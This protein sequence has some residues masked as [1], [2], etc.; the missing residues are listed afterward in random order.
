MTPAGLTAL[1][2]AALQ[3]AFDRVEPGA[4]PVVRRSA[5][6]GVDFQ[7]NGAMPLAKRLGQRPSELAAAVAAAADL[8]AMCDAVE[9]AP[10]GFINLTLS[11]SWLASL[12]SAQAGDPRLGVA[13]A[14][15]PRTVVVDY[16][17]PNVAK[18]MHAGHLRTTVIGDVICR[19]LSFAGHSVIRENHIGDWG[20]PFGMLIEHLVDKGEE[21]AAHELSVGDLDTFYRQARAE[22][23][24]SEEFQE[25]SRARVVL[26]QSGDAETMRL[27]RLLV[28][29]SVAYFQEVY[30]KLGVLL[31]PADIVGESFYNDLLP[32]VVEELAEQGLLVESQGARCVFP[33]GWTGRDGEPLPLIVQ[34]SDGG[35]GYA[36]TDLAAL[37]DRFGRLGADLALYVVGA[38]QAQHLAMCFAVAVAAGW[39]PS[40]DQAVHVPFGNMLGSDRKMF[41][42]RAGGTVKL[43]DL[44]D[45]AVA[46]A[47]NVVAEKNPDL[48]HRDDVA[49]MVGIGALKYADLSTDRVRDYVFDWDRMLSFDGN[50]APYLQYA[51]VRCL[52]I[53][54]RAEMEPARY[55]E[56]SVPVALEEPAERE[57]ALALLGFPEAVADTLATWSPHKLC[58]YLFDVAGLYTSFFETCPVLRAPSQE[59]RDSR[60]V[61]C[62]LTAATLGLGLSVLGIETPERM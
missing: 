38:P 5:Q 22:F 16:S 40:A 54:R 49:R 15:R 7:A 10:Q 30:D 36:A 9:V 62:A 50:T 20:T 42:T 53:F 47:A 55:L 35:F 6:P 12:V 43:V 44:L 32:V 41:K 33:P 24:A 31:T 13:P 56:G 51:R 46:R 19:L 8:G 18:E 11:P 45:E 59:Q 17:H 60:L 3:P 23:D 61:L 2:S 25:R 29:Q 28:D 58:A 52:S 34:K 14:D 1:L 21:A 39:V 4:D 48:E 26:L 27:R 37:R 57:L